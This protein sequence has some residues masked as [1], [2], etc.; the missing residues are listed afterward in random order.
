MC[1]NAEH[2]RLYHLQCKL[3]VLLTLGGELVEEDKLVP[4]HVM[5]HFPI[6]PQMYIV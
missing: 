5:L 1:I 3:N 6:L 2:M 4:I